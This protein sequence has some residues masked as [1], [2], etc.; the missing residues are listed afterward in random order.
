MLFKKR[1]QLE[2]YSPVWASI[3]LELKSIYQLHLKDLIIDI[4]HVGSTS[5]PG[6]AAKPIIDIDLVIEDRGALQAVIQELEQLRYE[7]RG[8][9]GI[10][11]REA[12]RQ[13]S[14]HTPLDG[15][16]RNWP[17]HNLYVCPSDSISLQNHL[18]LRD[19]LR[20]NPEKAKEYGELKKRLAVE[21]P[22]DI[23]VYIERKTPFITAILK[24][25]GFDELAIE[26]IRQENKLS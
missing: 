22:Y 1:I 18:A 2:D 16:N 19:Y 23:D 12:F 13:R 10:T 8:N 24:E 20:N 4:Q 3:F 26:K 15:S 25:V 6:L 7:Y 14:E 11:D 9:L 17:K 5:V 21:N